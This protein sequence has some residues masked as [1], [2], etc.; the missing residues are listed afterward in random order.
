MNGDVGIVSNLIKVGDDHRSSYRQRLFFIGKC[1][2]DVISRAPDVPRH[3]VISTDPIEHVNALSYDIAGIF[4]HVIT[5][6]I[7][8]KQKGVF[9]LLYEKT[10]G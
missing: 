8:I 1:F 3:G 10:F 9:K 4:R 2:F 6:S 7:V 5:D